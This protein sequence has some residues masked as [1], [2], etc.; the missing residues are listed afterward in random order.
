MH[1]VTQILRTTG[2]FTM[3]PEWRDKNKYRGRLSIRQVVFYLAG[4]RYCEGYN[5][6][7]DLLPGE[8]LRLVFEPDNPHDSKAVAVYARGL[9]IGYVPADR[10]AVITGVLDRRAT[11][12]AQVW[13]VYPGRPGRKKV[14]AKIE[15]ISDKK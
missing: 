13:E 1:R 10:N 3:K 14:K 6:V 5:K 7:R 2:I 9:K 8:P 11:I 15:V 4:A 12:T